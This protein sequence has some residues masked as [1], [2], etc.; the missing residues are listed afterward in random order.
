MKVKGRREDPLQG[1]RGRVH[2]RGR[3]NVAEGVEGVAVY[4]RLY[5]WEP[6]VIFSRARIRV[7]TV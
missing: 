3:G 1:Q 6:G 7:F 4:C 5:L 2:C